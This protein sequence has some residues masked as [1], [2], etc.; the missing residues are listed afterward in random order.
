MFGI[1]ARNGIDL[2]YHAYG[3]IFAAQT[4]EERDPQKHKD[5]AKVDDRSFL[6]PDTLQIRGEGAGHL[7]AQFGRHVL[8]QGLKALLVELDLNDIGGGCYSIDVRFLKG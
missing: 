3:G 4:G 2:S 5:G 7:A 1:I 6:L 8:Q